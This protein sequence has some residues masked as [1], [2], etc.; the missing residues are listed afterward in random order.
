MA[1]VFGADFAGVSVHR[2]LPSEYAS[3][4]VR[5]VS[6]GRE[7]W[8][9]DSVPALGPEFERVLAHELAHVLQ[10]ERGGEASSSRQSPSPTPGHSFTS[11]DTAFLEAE[12]REAADAAVVGNRPQLAASGPPSPGAQFD[13]PIEEMVGDAVMG[14]L[15]LPLG[16]LIDQDDRNKAAELIGKGVDAASDAIEEWE[17]EPL[18]YGELA[19]DV[20]FI[21][22]AL[23]A[24]AHGDK[25]VREVMGGASKVVVETVGGVGQM[26]LKPVESGKAIGNLAISLSGAGESMALIKALM[27]DP[28]NAAEAYQ[29]A[30]REKDQA[31]K[32][33]WDG[34]TEGYTEAWEE[35]RYGEIPG[36]LIVDIGSFFIPGGAAT[37]GAKAAPLAAKT[38]PAVT[39]AAPKVSQ[40]LPKVVTQAPQIA[41]KLGKTATTVPKATKALPKAI[42]AA[43]KATRAAPKA[44]KSVPKAGKSAPKAASAGQKAKP[45]MGPKPSAPVATRPPRSAAKGGKTA[46]PSSKSPPRQGKSAPRKAAPK[47]TPDELPS[48]RSRKAP[49]AAAAEGVRK[50]PPKGKGA[51]RGKPPKGSGGRGRRPAP[52]AAAPKAATPEQAARAGSKGHPSS[53]APAPVADAAMDV[54]KL[55]AAEAKAVQEGRRLP[56]LARYGDDAVLWLEQ[57]NLFGSGARKSLQHAGPETAEAIRRF[58]GSPGFDQVV[59]SWLNGTRNAKDGARFVMRSANELFG[60]LPPGSVRFEHPLIRGNKGIPMRVTDVVAHVGN[61]VAWEFKSVRALGSGAKRQFLLDVQR[62]V[63]ETGRI[64]GLK[65]FKWVFD[66]KKAAA[67][68]LTR[69]QVVQRFQNYLREF[70]KGLPEELVNE[71]VRAVDEMIV[72]HGP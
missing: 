18:K 3:F 52:T 6:E 24:S 70:Y 49:E 27:E 61:G 51:G 29:K 20:P 2:G 25:F 30:R 46:S 23:E 59:K 68:N 72:F 63:E 26:A 8:I 44:A 38:V 37:K 5:G 58:A 54:S 57:N 1:H 64:S 19:K 62:A 12:A 47:T 40:V 66:G 50:P 21:G 67:A 55:T 4:G 33:L 36:R 11:P 16:G 60:H 34:I 71:A 7:V 13:D 28:T 31:T 10:T 42:K 22:P 48:P 9:A 39:K 35:G 45:K 15:G 69:G 14:A 56:S 53:A 17:Q 32:Q 43:P 65:H 41:P